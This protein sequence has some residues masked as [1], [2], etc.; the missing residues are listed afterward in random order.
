MRQPDPPSQPSHRS[1]PPGPALR[2][3]KA[4]PPAPPQAGA[5]DAVALAVAA[6]TCFRGLLAFRGRARVEGSLAGEVVAAGALEI[7]SGA[8]VR[9]RVEVDELVLAGDLEGDVIARRRIELRPGA[10]ARGELRAPCLAIAEGSRVEGRVATG[11]A[12]GAG[13]P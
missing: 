12:P 10:R 8:R 6:G 3:P 4:G 9:A 7:V 13:F 11:D 2:S 1:P 5:P